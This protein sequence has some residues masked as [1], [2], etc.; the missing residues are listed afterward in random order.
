[1]RY[2]KITAL[3]LLPIVAIVLPFVSPDATITSI[4]FFA[5]LYTGAAIAWNLLSGYTG[6]ISL[7]HATFYGLG[8]YT[9]A[10]ICERWNVPGGYMPFLLLPLAGL[11]A[12]IFAVPLGWIALRTS[13]VGFAVVTLSYVFIFQ[14]L[15]YPD[16]HHP[17]F[18]GNIFPFP[19]VEW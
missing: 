15:A 11:V 9:L 3:L 4:G 2:S 14:L 8:T 5:L 19:F 13:Q 1:M 6:Y 16:W 17:W 7:G 10:I 18:T 12:A